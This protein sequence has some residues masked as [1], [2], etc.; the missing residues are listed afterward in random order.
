MAEAGTGSRTGKTLPIPLP[1]VPPSRRTVS[2]GR[3]K[4]SPAE[5]QPSVGGVC[6][7]LR[8]PLQLVQGDALGG[9][10]IRSSRWHRRDRAAPSQRS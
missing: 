9:S 1:Q 5:S 2:A 3:L 4:E 7:G 10:S 6:R 8:L